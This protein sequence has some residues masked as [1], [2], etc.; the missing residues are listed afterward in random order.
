MVVTPVARVRWRS[1]CH[2]AARAMPAEASPRQPVG[3]RPQPLGRDRHPERTRAPLRAAHAMRAWPS[4]HRKIA[5]VPDGELRDS[6]AA[7]IIAA[8]ECAEWRRCGLA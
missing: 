3:A 7:V 2:P 5:D 6:A 4:D 1:V 8:T